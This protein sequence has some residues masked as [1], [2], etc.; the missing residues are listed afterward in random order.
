LPEIVFTYFDDET[1]LFGQNSE[2]EK[3]VYSTAFS[4]PDKAR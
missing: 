3:A 4:T 2:N 1:Q